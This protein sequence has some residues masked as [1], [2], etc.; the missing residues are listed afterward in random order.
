MHKIKF[1]PEAIHDYQFDIFDCDQKFS[2]KDRDWRIECIWEIP[3]AKFPKIRAE[4]TRDLEDYF[5]LLGKR[6]CKDTRKWVADLH[7]IAV[8][9]KYH[10]LLHWDEQTGKWLMIFVLKGEYKQNLQMWNVMGICDST[11]W[12]EEAE[13]DGLVRNW[14]TTPLTRANN[15][16]F[17]EVRRL[18]K[19]I[20]LFENLKEVY[21][22]LEYEL[23]FYKSLDR[24]V[25]KERTARV[26]PRL[27]QVAR[28]RK[29]AERQLEVFAARLKF[30][31]G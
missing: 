28:L 12:T 29:W 25:C 2:R 24:Q 20:D 5:W 23:E 21:C 4:L 31:A 1:T 19:S 9:K 8:H 3:L 26:Q 30:N 10:R 27:E 18:R 7:S 13:E 11:A 16:D 14:Y 15:Y 6:Y 17:E 22:E